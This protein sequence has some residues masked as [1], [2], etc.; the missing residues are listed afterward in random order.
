MFDQGVDGPDCDAGHVVDDPPLPSA[1]AGGEADG[2]NH[3][4]MYQLELE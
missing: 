3:H 4:L 1:G 2:D